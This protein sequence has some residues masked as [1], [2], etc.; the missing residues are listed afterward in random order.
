MDELLKQLP[1]LGI[2]GV[3]IVAF[4]GGVRYYVKVMLPKQQQEHREQVEKLMETIE[5]LMSSHREERKE[6]S[7]TL[8]RVTTSICDRLDKIDGDLGSIKDAIARK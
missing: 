8:E 7:A 5:N 4:I 2:G 6:F 3:L 1:N